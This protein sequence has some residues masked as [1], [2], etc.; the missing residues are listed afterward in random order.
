MP[1]ARQ[2][3]STPAA[4]EA[5]RRVGATVAGKFKLVRLIGVGGMGT[6]YEA[7][8]TWT[9]R[10]VALKI[11]HPRVARDRDAAE[12]FFQEARAAT[13]IAHPNI[14]DVLD[15]GEDTADGSLF[16]VQELL[17]GEDLHARLNA[18]GRLPPREAL[19]VLLPI[20]DALAT[21]H[22]RGILHRDVKPENIVLARVEGGGVVP[23]LV[24]FGVSKVV[25]AAPRGK[26]LTDDG[27]TVGTPQYMPPEQAR[28]DTELDPRTDV[29][30]LG[31]VLFEALSGTA[32]FEAA[33]PSLLLV[34]IITRPPPRIDTLVQG[35]PRALVDAVAKALEPDRARRFHTV[36]AFS[37]ALRA[38]PD[39]DLGAPVDE[40][41]TRV[42]PYPSPRKAHPNAPT[43][44]IWSG[45]RTAA[46]VPLRTRALHG[47]GALGLLGLLGLLIAFARTPLPP[48][49]ASVPV[50][51]TALPPPPG[52]APA[53]PSADRALLAAVPPAA[54]RPAPAAPIAASG[55]RMGRSQPA[56]PASH[57]APSARPTRA[58]RPAGVS[59]PRPTPPLV[60]P[61][62]AEGP[63]PE[64]TPE[65][66]PVTR[67]ANG[68]VILA[69]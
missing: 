15:M 65:P 68:S 12:R 29:W 13:H 44:I 56:A 35:L 43:S 64:P 39:R 36:G 55:P 14:V 19:E 27:I 48:P 66:T 60:P 54:P 9:H 67:A 18:R 50:Q 69:P 16:I 17:D 47:L 6:V 53:P 33:T 37:A 1:A 11:L 49:A 3:E 59:L 26:R 40:A 20:M 21:S 4:A 61:Q 38:I 31:A 34:E 57:G 58:R 41:V 8:N 2:S 23:K 22:R 52:Q 7:T 46:S 25:R 51:S 45:S 30:A 63:A 28:G 32:P 10:R 42:M 5:T 62:P 24:D